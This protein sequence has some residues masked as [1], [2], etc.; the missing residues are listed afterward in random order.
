MKITTH[1][2]VFLL[3]KI[4]QDEVTGNL[5]DSLSCLGGSN[6]PPATNKKKGW[7]HYD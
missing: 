4:W 1:A 3:T 7:C 6:P 2:V 5:Q